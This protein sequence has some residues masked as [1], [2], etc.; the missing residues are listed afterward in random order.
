[1]PEIDGK[2]AER[3]VQTN[4]EMSDYYV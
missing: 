2:I 1:V 3:D 4:S